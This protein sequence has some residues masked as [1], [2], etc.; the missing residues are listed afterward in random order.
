MQ[1]MVE[2]VVVKAIYPYYYIYYYSP[3]PSS[4]MI[5]QNTTLPLTVEIGV[6]NDSS[7][8]TNVSYS[9][10]GSS[11]RAMNFSKKTPTLYNASGILTDLPEGNHTL[12]VYGF[13]VNAGVVIS[14]QETF[15]INKT[16]TYPTITV[17]SPLNQTYT[18]NE[19][20]LTFT[21]NAQIKYS[22]YILDNLNDKSFQGNITL[23]ELS[24]GSH[25]LHLSALTEWNKYSQ[26]TIYFTIK[27]DTSSS[28]DSQAIIIIIAV[29][30]LAL[31]AVLLV[32][33]FK[34]KKAK[35]TPS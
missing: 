4:E 20:P 21:I 24:E 8:I 7:E 22:Y 17:F 12:L 15:T 10:D 27:S 11:N 28:I 6:R 2:D 14:E 13:D 32:I 29:I 19:V 31:V 3:R 35:Q 33:L 34:R 25:T 5:Y 23:N 16:F 9:L 30:A 18:K 26:Q 1:P